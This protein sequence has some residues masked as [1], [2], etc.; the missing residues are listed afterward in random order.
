M[1]SR[2]NID[3]KLLNRII[4]VAYG[5]ANLIDKIRIYYLASG[6]KEINRLLV[7]YKINAL[8]IGNLEKSE[9]PDEIIENVKVNTG[10]E[11]KGLFSP[12]IR[13]LYSLMYKPL[14]TTAVILILVAGVTIF[15]LFNNIN[16]NQYSERQVQLA[17]KQVKQSLVLV[18]KIFNRTSSKLENDILK[19]QVARP[20]HEGV[21]TINELF[22]GG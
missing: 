10:F 15:M 19:E 1:K 16:R 14:F 12:V 17:E 7:E 22:R 13:F 11:E 18:N 20:V 21:A 5:D 2:L 3:E 9:C 6:N 4:S 8:A